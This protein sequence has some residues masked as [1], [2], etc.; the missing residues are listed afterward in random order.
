LSMAK[1]F[2]DILQSSRFALIICPPQRLR[3]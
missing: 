3:C 1:N 2:L